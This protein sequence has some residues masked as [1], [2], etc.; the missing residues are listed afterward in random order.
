MLAL[1]EQVD[2]CI[3]GSMTKNEAIRWAGS[4]AELARIL[5]ITSQAIYDWKEVPRG[6]QYELQ[7]ISNG[8]L[9][10]NENTTQAA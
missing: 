3:E 5:N 8:A 2:L 6:R 1:K 9:K 7:H 4:V 10:I